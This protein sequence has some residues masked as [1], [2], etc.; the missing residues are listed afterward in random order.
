M[1]RETT[2][3]RRAHERDAWAEEQT[4]TTLRT[5]ILSAAMTLAWPSAQAMAADGWGAS[6]SFGPV[7]PTATN[8][9]IH[10][11]TTLVSGRLPAL[12]HNVGPLFLWP[13]I[14]NPTSDLIQTTMD[15]WSG[16]ENSSYCGGNGSQW[17]VEAS[18]FNGGQING[19][20]VAIDPDD[21]VT[22]EY[23]LGA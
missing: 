18:V 20:T 19:P 2:K 9:I 8:H 6:W 5:T 22:I 3:S 17:C 7:H 12:P 4:M 21:H 15:D 13:G 23:E 1:P 11:K 14:S 10:T 16:T